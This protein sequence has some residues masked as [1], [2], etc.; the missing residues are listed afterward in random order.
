MTPEQRE[1]LSGLLKAI[2]RIERKSQ[3]LLADPTLL[4]SEAGQDALDV[5]CM[6][7]MAVGE[8]P[9]RFEQ[10]GP[11]CWRISF[12]RWIGRAPWAFAM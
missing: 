12:R 10:L 4:D 3:P 2:A 8:G 7:F 5:I 6:Q 1:L 9:K 11:M